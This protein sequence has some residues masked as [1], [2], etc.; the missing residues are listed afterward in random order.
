VAL[1]IELTSVI[2][3][4]ITQS[5]PNQSPNQ[6]PNHP[7][8]PLPESPNEKKERKGKKKKR[9]FFFLHPIICPF[10]QYLFSIKFVHLNT[11][12]T[13]S[14]HRTLLSTWYALKCISCQLVGGVRGTPFFTL[15]F[16]FLSLYCASLF[17]VVH[18]GFP[19]TRR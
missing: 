6:S 15:F 12:D 10:L 11:K 5:S 3:P 4:I 7:I 9:L 2:I 17:H 16:A 1:H 18:L 13:M 19:S 14:A 8:I